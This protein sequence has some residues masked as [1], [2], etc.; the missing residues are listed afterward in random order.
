M[1][2]IDNSKFHEYKKLYNQN[3]YLIIEDV[4]SV[5]DCEDIKKKSQE[6]IELPE[7][8]VALNVHRK[9]DFFGKLFQIII[10]LI[11]LNLFKSQI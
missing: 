3:G 2:K 5:N 7:Y 4:L 10:L 1:F 8:P 9:S 11:L 6:F